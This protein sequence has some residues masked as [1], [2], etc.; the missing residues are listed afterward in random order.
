MDLGFAQTIVTVFSKSSSGRC[1]M[2]TFQI[3]CRV[4]GWDWRLS[5]AI[6]RGALHQFG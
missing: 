2:V 6:A 5:K 3:A 4:A 1:E